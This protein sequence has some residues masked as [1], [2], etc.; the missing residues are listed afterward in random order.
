MKTQVLVGRILI[1]LTLLGVLVAIYFL[2]QYLGGEG[3]AFP[4]H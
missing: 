2:K 4:I 3:I 1:C